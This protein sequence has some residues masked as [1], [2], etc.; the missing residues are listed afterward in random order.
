MVRKTIPV[1]TII[2]IGYTVKR[3][4][5]GTFMETETAM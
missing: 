1:Y 2:V 3:E 5:D 4:F